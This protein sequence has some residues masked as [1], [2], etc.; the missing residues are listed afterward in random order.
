MTT[1]YY[2]MRVVLYLFILLTLTLHL[3]HTHID[4][5][6]IIHIYTSL[7]LFLVFED[8]TLTLFITCINNFVKL[9]LN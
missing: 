8:K 5:W 1:A 7:L 9:M 2:K 6:N 3:T 4:P